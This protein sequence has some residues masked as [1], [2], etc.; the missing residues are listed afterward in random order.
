MKPIIFLVRIKIQLIFA[1]WGNF[2][3]DLYIS[4]LE[5]ISRVSSILKSQVG[6]LFAFTNLSKRTNPFMSSSWFMVADSGVFCLKWRNQ[7]APYTLKKWQNSCNFRHET[8]FLSKFW[9]IAPLCV[10]VR[11]PQESGI[12]KINAAGAGDYGFCFDNTESFREDKRISVTTSSHQEDNKPDKNLAGNKIT[13]FQSCCDRSI[14]FL[15]TTFWWKEE[16]FKIPV[17]ERNM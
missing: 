16:K 11:N 12:I 13:T 14:L 9:S 17:S 6:R 10:F 4:F 7:T 1:K 8:S 2:H 5:L 3:Y 15:L